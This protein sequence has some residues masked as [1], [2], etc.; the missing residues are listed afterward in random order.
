MKAAIMEINPI[1]IFL[2]LFTIGTCS[3]LLLLILPLLLYDFPL[4][5][6]LILILWIVSMYLIGFLKGL[7]E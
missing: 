7:S 6:L 4:L 5:Q 1:H 3:Y 2:I